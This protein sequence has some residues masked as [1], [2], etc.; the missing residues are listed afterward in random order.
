MWSA[1]PVFA[2]IS[3]INSISNTQ[4]TN[5]LKVFVCRLTFA[6]KNL[7]ETPSKHLINKRLDI[8]AD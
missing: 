8:P 1:L 4:V 2:R 5:F 3:Q 7:P 6:S